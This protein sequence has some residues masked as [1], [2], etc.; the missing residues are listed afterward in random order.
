MAEKDVAEYLSAGVTLTE[1]LQDDLL[2][3]NKVEALAAKLR[4]LLVK[5]V[6]YPMRTYATGTM[7]VLPL[8]RRRSRRTLDCSRGSK[9]DM[10]FMAACRRGWYRMGTCMLN[11]YLWRTKRRPRR[12]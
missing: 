5:D 9:R 3:A 12:C 6:T 10:S 1:G 2:Q 4:D 7:N 11:I 8:L